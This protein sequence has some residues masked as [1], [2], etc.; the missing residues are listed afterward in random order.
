MFCEICGAFDCGDHP[1]CGGCN[2]T[3]NGPQCHC[4]DIC[5]CDHPVSEHNWK[6]IECGIAGCDCTEPFVGLEG[7]THA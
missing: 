6:G 1:R 4:G 2:H 3:H 5:I 7:L